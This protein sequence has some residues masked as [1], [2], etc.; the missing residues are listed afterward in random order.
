MSL[1]R[2]TFLG[3]SAA[4][5]T[6]HRGLSG[7][8]VKADADL[9][10]FDCGEGSQRQMVR[11]GTGFTVDVAFFTHFHADHYLGIIGFLRTLGMTGRTE[12]MHLYGP[13]P[14]RRLLHQAVHLG[15]ESLAF[16]VEIH[17][18]K[19]GDV[20]RRGGYTVQAVGVDH[21]IHALGYVLAEDERPGRFHLEKARELGVP[22]GPSFGKLQRGEAVTLPDGRVVKPED[23]LGM[24]R[25]GR[26]LVISGDTRPCPALVQ[27]AKD[28]DLLVHESTFSD[29]EQTRAVETRHSTAREA[30]Q[31]AKE[32][33]AKRLILTHLSSRHD[34]DPGR[35]L[36]QAREA[37]KGPVEV[38]F[39]GLTVELPLRD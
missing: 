21:R 1:L 30:A 37:F 29:D 26:R 35:L 34:T 9:L 6:L 23:V 32:A 4:Q 2:L 3:T 19:D 15:L 24:A 31:V 8:A 18:L 22:E 28:A 36:T 10:L 17:E 20:V 11:F 25:P 38:A 12:P 27:A 16:P 33:G 7:L 39:D 13:P 5:P 14:A